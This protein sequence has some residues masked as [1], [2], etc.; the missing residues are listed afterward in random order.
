MLLTM[1]F[2]V[3]ISTLFLSHTHINFIYFYRAQRYNNF[4]CCNKRRYILRH[5]SY[6]LSSTPNFRHNDCDMSS[7]IVLRASAAGGLHRKINN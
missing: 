4:Y 3:L 7:L 2:K 6:R 1:S 5:F